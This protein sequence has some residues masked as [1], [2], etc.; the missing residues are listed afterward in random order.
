MGLVAL[1]AFYASGPVSRMG[2]D[3]VITMITNRVRRRQKQETPA[4]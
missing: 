2:A 3:E 4:T 1:G